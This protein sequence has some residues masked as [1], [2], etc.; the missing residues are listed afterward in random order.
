MV[1]DEALVSALT[2]LLSR[3]LCWS[4]RVEVVGWSPRRFR[5]CDTAEEDPRRIIIVILISINNEKIPEANEKK[6]N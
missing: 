6:P 2:P 1:D 3:E 5:N 4:I